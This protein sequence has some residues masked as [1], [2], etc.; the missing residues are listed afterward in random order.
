MGPTAKTCLE[1]EYANCYSSVENRNI[2]RNLLEKQ[3]VVGR[4]L[5]HHDI[6]QQDFKACI[7]DFQA[8]LS[9]LNEYIEK[10]NDTDERSSHEVSD[11]VERLINLD[12][13]LIDL[14][15]DIYY[16]LDNLESSLFN[17]KTLNGVFARADATEDKKKEIVSNRSEQCISMQNI[18]PAKESKLLEKLE[19]N[20]NTTNN[21]NHYLL[22]GT[23]KNETNQICQR[24]SHQKD[25]HRQKKTLKIRQKKTE[26]DP[27]NPLEKDSSE[28]RNP[29][30]EM[31]R[32]KWTRL[33]KRK[34][35]HNSRQ[36][37]CNF[38]KRKQTQNNRMDW[39]KRNARHRKS[40]MVT[41]DAKQFRKQS[42]TIRGVQIQS[43]KIL[44]F[45]GD[46]VRSGLKKIHPKLRK[47]KKT[48]VE[49][50]KG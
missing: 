16:K 14:A 20:Q 24:P 49:E 41:T 12:F 48:K 4:T 26:R 8:C 5:L 15:V 30:K 10:L 19:Q 38:E 6:R 37:T 34:R 42:R 2:Y 23:E 50:K 3:T 22:D 40:R 47:R 11:D 43:K 18:E 32:K 36:R 28:L 21:E 33:P 44:F 46:T 1:A 39:K 7:Q 9:L 35:A 17:K 29:K 13:D 45:R 25:S 27:G 31:W